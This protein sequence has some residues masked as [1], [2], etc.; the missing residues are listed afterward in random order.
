[1]ATKKAASGRRKVA[2][3]AG[4]AAGIAGALAGGYLLYQYSKPRR[5][6][7]KAWVVAARKNAA[8]EAKKLSRMGEKDYHRIVEKAMRH[9]GAIQK[10]GAPEVMAAIRDAKAEWKH[11][12]AEAKKAAKAPRSARKPAKRKAK[13]VVRRK[14]RK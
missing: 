3:G 5:K 12:Q 4:I 14:S 13:K 6:K 9:Y 7:A 8:V 2:V 1:M 11:I 10:A